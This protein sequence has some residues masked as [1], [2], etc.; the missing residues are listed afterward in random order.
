MVLSH[1]RSHQQQRQ[2][3]VMWPKCGCPS[4][5]LV[6]T[7]G[8]SIP[9]PLHGSTRGKFSSAGCRLIQFGGES[10]PP[11]TGDGLW[12]RQARQDL[13]PIGA[14]TGRRC[15][16]RRAAVTKRYPQ[17]VG[18]G[19]RNRGLTLSFHSH[20]LHKCKIPRGTP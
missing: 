9:T 3:W 8:Y 11:W 7:Y 15:F 14:Y 2:S 4:G 1:S 18:S 13:Q 5:S 20:S 17:P 16:S 6:P 10:A 19:D 12:R